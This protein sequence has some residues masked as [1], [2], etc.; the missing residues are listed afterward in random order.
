MQ[1]DIKSLKVTV[2]GRLME[3]RRSL[4]FSTTKMRENLKVSATTYNRYERGKMLPG[5]P[6]LYFAAEKLGISLDWLVCGKGPIYYKDKEKKDSLQNLISG[7]SEEEIKN[8]LEH[9]NRIPLLR[10]E[11]LAC[12]YKFMEDHKELVSPQ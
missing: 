8:F 1:M 2:S 6:A 9:M 10:H 3:L 11:I 12:F 5:F 4:H 7:S